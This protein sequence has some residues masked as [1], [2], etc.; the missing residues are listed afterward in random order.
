MEKY[1][2]VYVAMILRV[3]EEGILKPVAVEWEDGTLYEIDRVTDERNAPP[4]LTGGVLTRKY[5][6]LIG[7]KE[8]K[9]YAEKRTNRWFLERI[10]RI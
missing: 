5:T 8:K 6:V 4:E 1:E 3:S 7:G 10:A 9:L 2:K